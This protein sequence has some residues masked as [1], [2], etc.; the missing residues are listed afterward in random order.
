[1]FTYGMTGGQGAATTPLHARTTTTPYGNY[2]FPFNL[3][4]LAA[5]SGAVYVSRWTVLQVQP[6]ERS[7]SRAL[8]K[9][10]FSFVEIISPCPTL[11]G[12]MNRL[13]TGL[14]FLKY[15]QANT[16]VKHDVNLKDAEIGLD[17]EIITGN[18]IDIERPTLEELQKQEVTGPLAQK[19]AEEKT[20]VE[21]RQKI[22]Q[23]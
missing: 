6:L 2:E 9:K 11:Y 7:I 1:N 19:K 5:G 20:V 4:Y 3:A 13:S 23:E 15:Y 21:E 17:G 22:E 16:V 10:G 14:D 12:R 8:D 18:F